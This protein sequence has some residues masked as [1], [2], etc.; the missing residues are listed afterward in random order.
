MKYPDDKYEKM[1]LNLL[2]SFLILLETRTV[3]GAMAFS[4]LEPPLFLQAIETFLFFMINYADPDAMDHKMFDTSDY[5]KRRSELL[6][7]LG[8]REYLKEAVLLAPGDHPPLT[9]DN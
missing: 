1:A 2:P 9:S 4:T 7:A 8:L 3:Q 6:K 5:L